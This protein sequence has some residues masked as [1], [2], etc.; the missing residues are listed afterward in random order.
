VE[1]D[2]DNF[3]GHLRWRYGGARIF[4]NASF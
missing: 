4:V 3:D 2:G 1:V